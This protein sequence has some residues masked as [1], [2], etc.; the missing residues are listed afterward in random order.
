MDKAAFRNKALGS[1]WGLVIGDAL[2]AYLEFSD[3]NCHEILMEYKDGGPH[4][5][6]AGDWTDDTAMA[7]AV[8]DSL[9]KG[10]VDLNDIMDNFTEWMNHGKYSSNGKCFDIGNATEEALSTYAATRRH[11]VINS[12]SKGNG[13]LMRLTPSVVYA[14]AHGKDFSVVEAI[15]DLTHNNAYMHGCVQ[16]MTGVMFS[17]FEGL[18]STNTFAYKTRKACRPTGLAHQTLGCALWAFCNSRGFQEG[19]LKAVNLGGDSDTIGAVYGQIAGAW[20]GFDRIP[21]KWK[22][23]LQC[24][25]YLTA[26]FDSLVESCLQ[27]GIIC[28]D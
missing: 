15:S 26:M 27:N 4:N 21:P 11:S 25:D 24:N 23:G 6:R 2:G 9:R 5:I 28:V 17:H 13:S 8:C 19:L 22:T 18:K 7:L 3:K 14:Y 20:Y 10:R 1:L 16:V 12:Q